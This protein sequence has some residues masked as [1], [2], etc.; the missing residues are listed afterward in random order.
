MDYTAGS[1]DQALVYDDDDKDRILTHD[2]VR[3]VA[4]YDVASRF[5][6]VALLQMSGPTIS[7]GDGDD[8]EIEAE[9]KCVSFLKGT[10]ARSY[11]S[12]IQLLNL[13]R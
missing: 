2:F 4:R 10:H 6:R 12:T 11:S 9:A 8:D 7:L 3:K 13:M 1:K 5:C